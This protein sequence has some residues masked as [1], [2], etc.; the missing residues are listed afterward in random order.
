M[1]AD[2]PPPGASPPVAPPP[3]APVGN[4]GLRIAL[5]LSVALN[6]AVVGVVAGALWRAGGD[7]RPSAALRDLGFGPFAAA[8]TDED[9]RALRRD[10]LRRAPDLRA[11]RAEMRAEMTE[12]L[13]VLRADPFAP[14]RLRQALD[15]ATARTAD[16]MALGRG[17]LFDHIA[18]MTPEARRAFAD[19][20]ERAMTRGRGADPAR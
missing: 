10:F 15:Q 5:A 11:A 3:V 13:A 14:D 6:L 8:L 16:R 9:R 17:L 7:G 4:R 19:R 18:A 1:A 12:V 2:T 20:L